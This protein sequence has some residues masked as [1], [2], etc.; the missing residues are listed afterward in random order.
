[1]GAAFGMF[2]LRQ[3]YAGKLRYLFFRPVPCADLIFRTGAPPS[4]MSKEWT[5]AT[6]DKIRTGVEREAADP[7]PLNPITHHKVE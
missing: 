6:K 4:T 7:I 1:M 3:S 2:K 5:D